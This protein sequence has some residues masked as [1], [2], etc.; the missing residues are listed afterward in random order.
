MESPCVGSPC[1]GSPCV[2]SPCE[3]SPCVGSPCEGSPCVWGVGEKFDTQSPHVWGHHVWGHHVW[4]HH[5]WGVG[6]RFDTQSHCAGGGGDTIYSAFKVGQNHIY[7]L[8]MHGIFSRK[9]IT[10]TVIYGVYIYMVLASPTC[11][12]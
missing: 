2:G 9:C 4:G 12:I 11:T 8:C 6:E 10:H 7:T 3:G 1:V 5:V